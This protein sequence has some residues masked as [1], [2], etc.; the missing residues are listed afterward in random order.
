MKNTISDTWDEKRKR[1]AARWNQIRSIVLPSAHPAHYSTTVFLELAAAA[2]ATDVR[3][4]EKSRRAGHPS[5]TGFLS[6]LS[7][8]FLE[9]LRQRDRS[10]HGH[11]GSRRSETSGSKTMRAAEA[12]RNQIATLHPLLPLDEIPTE[13]R[14]T[15][16]RHAET[17]YLP[18]LQLDSWEDL[19]IMIFGKVK[20]STAALLIF[21]K[22]MVMIMITMYNLFSTGFKNPFIV[23]STYGLMTLVFY[24]NVKKLPFTVQFQLYVNLV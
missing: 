23:C 1:A 3:R 15:T 24:L 16:P 20:F 7:L 18:L 17:I 8:S 2:S 12:A 22:S 6:P 5:A 19:H 10:L 13:R 14:S 9:A 11:S 21:C 4:S